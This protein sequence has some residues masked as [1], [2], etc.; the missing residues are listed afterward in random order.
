MARNFLSDLNLNQNS[1][2]AP[3]FEN[4]GTAPTTPVTGQIYYNTGSNRLEFWDGTIWQPLYDNSVSIAAGSSSLLDITNNELSVQ[5]LLITTT[6]VEPTLTTITAFVSASYTV[7]TE[8]QEGDIIVIA[9]ATDEADRTW[10]HNGG[11]AVTDADFTRVSS[12]L[13]DGSVR[14][15]LSGTGAI[16]YTAGTGV[17]TIDADAIDGTLLDW[18]VTGDQIYAG[19]I[20]VLDTGGNFT[21]TEIEGVLSELQGNINATANV[22]TALST[23]TV[24]ATTY[25][26]T[27]DG[28]TDDVILAAATISLAGLLTGADKTK[29]DGIEPLADVTDAINVDAAGAVMNTDTTTAA[30]SFVIDEDTMASDLATQ[31]PTQQSVKAYV[32]NSIS[33]IATD[34]LAAT[35]VA[36]NTTGSNDIIVTNGQSITSS[37]ATAT[38]RIAI[39]FT[40]GGISSDFLTIRTNNP[41]ANS[42]ALNIG[43]AG[44]GLEYW[45]NSGVDLTRLVISSPDTFQFEATTVEPTIVMGGVSFLGALTQSTLTAARTWTLPDTTG[46]IALTSDIPSVTTFAEKTTFDIIGT[47]VATSFVL[48]HG[49]ANQWVNITVVQA[50]A[51]FAVVTTDIEFTDA[52]NVTVKFDVAPAVLTD[53]K[54]I[55]HG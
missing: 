15:A 21:A 43:A 41:T 6:T 53:Y 55:I 10:I 17:I 19:L 23:G 36:G 1:L 29:L 12:T 35:L 44:A 7:G 42:G 52:N 22:S 18:G 51:P 4:L 24:T 49:Y 30:M 32:D 14:A 34:T 11:T 8:F 48:N 38:D 9:S 40:S 13:T 46:T 54:V 47:G 5:N 16:N 20:P 26:I 50:S 25:G 27:S 33:A 2:I 31:V 3:Q 28:S 45:S 39:D 37:D